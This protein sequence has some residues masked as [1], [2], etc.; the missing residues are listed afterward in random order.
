MKLNTLTKNDIGRPV[1]YR[2]GDVSKLGLIKRWNDSFIFVVFNAGDNWDN[3][4]DYTGQAC[5]PEYVNII[6]K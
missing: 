5:S 2:D 3:F 4:K 1:M 6:N